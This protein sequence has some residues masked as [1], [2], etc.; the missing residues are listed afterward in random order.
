MNTTVQITEHVSYCH[1]FA[2]AGDA[3]EAVASGFTLT[4]TFLNEVRSYAC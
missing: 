3:V 2:A 4:Y 1:G